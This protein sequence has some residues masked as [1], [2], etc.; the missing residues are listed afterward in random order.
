MRATQFPET[1]IKL[2]APDPGVVA[3]TLHA[4]ILED[5]TEATNSAALLHPAILLLSRNSPS[6]HRRNSPSRFLLLSSTLSAPRRLRMQRPSAGIASLGQ[7]LGGL[8]KTSNDRPRGLAFDSAP[9]PA[10]ADSRRENE[11]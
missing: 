11:L 9:M 8:V 4:S 7:V 6:H 1:C 2:A 10:L 3:I 5:T